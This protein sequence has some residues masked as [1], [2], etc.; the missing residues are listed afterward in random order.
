[1]N[2]RVRL[3]L[4]VRALDIG[5][6]ER[7]FFELVKKIDHTKFE[8]L[9]IT[10]HKG[11]LDQ[12]IEGYPYFNANK[13]GRWDFGALLRLRKKIREFKP[14]A[15]YTFMPDMNI[16]LALMKFTGLGNFKLIWGQFGSEPDFA[17]YGKIRRRVYEVQQKL[18]FMSDAMISDGSRGI[19]FLKKFHH[20]LEPS[21]VIV[22]GTD[23]VRFAR[24]EE[25]RKAFRTQY[26]LSE[27][28]IAI[29][30]CS[31][32]D[33]MK[34]Y[35]VLAK[36]A[37]RILEKYPNVSF[38][39]IGYGQDSIMNDAKEYLGEYSNRFTWFGKQSK[40]EKIISGWD[41]YCSTSLYGEGF[42]NAII[43]AMACS[44]PIIATDVGDAPYQ[45]EG[46]GLILKPGDDEALFNSLDQW[47]KEGRYKQKGIASKE[48]AKEYFSSALM[49]KKTEDYI[50][51]I[52]EGAN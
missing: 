22:S 5:G 14:Q 10:T 48:R 37:K 1:M 52:L 41:I 35:H 15:I 46:V 24:N 43:E 11:A 16:T 33:P 25:Y 45:V 29:G 13:T 6:A 27:S 42:S 34:G 40:P 7:Q 47:I 18:E 4:A 9:V 49:A 20:K 31:R 30:I 21:T 50:L 3:I 17:A 28:D 19:E 8:V 38:Y 12:E 51:K 32:L 39:S 44:L 23:V 36:A 2:N 26:N